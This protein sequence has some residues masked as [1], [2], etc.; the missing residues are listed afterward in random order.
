MLLKILCG[1]N[2]KRYTSASRGNSYG[3]SSLFGYRRA[4]SVVALLSAHTQHFHR[5]C[6]F[7]SSQ[8]TSNRISCQKAPANF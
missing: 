8:R 4:G 6:S 7:P 2:M 5:Y 1:E 3:I